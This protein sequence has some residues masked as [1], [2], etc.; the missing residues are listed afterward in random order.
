[1]LQRGLFAIFFVSES[2]ELLIQKGI[3]LWLWFVFYAFTYLKYVTVRNSVVSLLTPTMKP[4]LST[5]CSY[6][7]YVMQISEVLG[8]NLN[9]DDNNV[10]MFR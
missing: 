10:M 1:M 6:R 9:R 2:F 5:L 4:L 3:F 7:E 8:N